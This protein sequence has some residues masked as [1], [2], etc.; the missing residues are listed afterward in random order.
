MATDEPDETWYQ[1]GLKFYT[2]KILQLNPFDF[3]PYFHRTKEFEDWWFAYYREG[4]RP[5]SYSS[6][7]NMCF[8]VYAELGEGKYRYAHQRNSSFPMLF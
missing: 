6:V 3:T 4:N 5:F 2:K 7:Y 8:F 1:E